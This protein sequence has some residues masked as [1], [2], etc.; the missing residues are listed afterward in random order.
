M[1]VS[2][3]VELESALSE[4]FSNAKVL[5][6]RREAAKQAFRS[7]SSSVVANVWNVLNVHVFRK[8]FL[9]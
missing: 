5:E 2:G 3:K 4:L 6:E 7:L 8:A 1:Q 9:E